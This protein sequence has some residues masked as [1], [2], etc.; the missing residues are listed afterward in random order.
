MEN[1]YTTYETATG[2]TLILRQNE[3][4]SQTHIPMVDGNSDYAQYLLWLENPEAEQST[5]NV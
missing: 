4:G 3:D 5:P 2:G 1:K